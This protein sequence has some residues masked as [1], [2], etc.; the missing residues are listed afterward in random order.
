MT[1]YK[2]KAHVTKVYDGDTI[3]VSIDC[4]FGIEL[5][6][7]KIGEKCICSVQACLF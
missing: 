4:G 1:E 2:Y 6:K 7:Q 5:Q 3:T